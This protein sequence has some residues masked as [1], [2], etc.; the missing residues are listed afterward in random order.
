MIGRFFGHKKGTGFQKVKL[1]NDEDVVPPA[2][3]DMRATI[4]V[5]KQ[6]SKRAVMTQ[7]QWRVPLPCPRDVLPH[8]LVPSTPRKHSLGGRCRSDFQARLVCRRVG[9][10]IVRRKKT[11]RGREADF[12]GEKEIEREKERERERE[13]ESMCVCTCACARTCACTCACACVYAHAQV[14][15]H[16]TCV[17]TF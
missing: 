16:P 3:G 9:L 10:Q 5:C 12:E 4:C 2:L 6:L 1:C 8:P 17:R 11:E 13:R 14:H 15:V 7:P